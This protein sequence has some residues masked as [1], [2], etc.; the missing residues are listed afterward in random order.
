MPSL[1]QTQKLLQTAKLSPQQIQMIKLIEVPTVELEERIQQEIQENPALEEGK[2]EIEESY[3]Q[4]EQQDEMQIDDNMDYEEYLDGDDIPDY[5]L[6][7]NNRSR[8]DK[9]EDIP[10]SVGVSFHEHLEEQLTHLTEQEIKI[11][12]YVIGNIDEDG[13][14]KR[15]EDA[16]VDD[17]A[18]QTGEEVNEEDIQNVIK[19]V[20]Q[21]DPPGVC[22]R[23]LQECLSIQLHQKKNTDS[24]HLAIIIIDKYY[25]LFI[26]K[27]YE[28]IMMRLNITE[29]Q[30]RDV[31]SEISRL[32]PKPGNAWGTVLEKNMQEIIPDFYLE[33]TNGKLELSLNNVNIPELRIS[34]GYKEMFEDYSKNKKAN[35][36]M[37]EAVSFVKQKLDSARW[38]IEALKQRNNTMMMVMNEIIKKQ[39]DFF[40]TGDETQLKP[41]ILKDISDRTGL[42]IS[43]VSRVSNSKYIQTSFGIYQLKYFFSEAMK[44][45]EGE[46]VSSREIKKIMKDLIECEDKRHPITDEKIMELLK[47]KKYVIARRTVAKYR[48]MLGI[49]VA[50]LRKEI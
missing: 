49:P 36:S 39:Y 43:T 9:H 33:E 26:K 31:L 42:D 30:F 22:A 29:E 32:N 45:D 3:E 2:E 10:F 12:K 48:E 41:M 15:K 20:Q 37:K 19:K 14:L 50:R 16:M 47:E 34:K 1:S 44:T 6:Q 27:H 24:I 4:D 21:L 40:M 7:S 8:D 38:F 17:I 5:K 11:A 23:T 28:K 25:E 46:D 35:K 13:Y 18:F